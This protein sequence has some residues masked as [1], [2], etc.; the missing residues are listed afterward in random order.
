MS[1]AAETHLQGIIHHDDRTHT[2]HYFSLT[3]GYIRIDNL[4]IIEVFNLVNELDAAEADWESMLVKW[5]EG[6][7]DANLNELDAA[8][9]DWESALAKWVLGHW[10]ANP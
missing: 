6:Y 7:R 1:D 8:G 5:A 9:D 3:A 2:Y 4:T 10:G